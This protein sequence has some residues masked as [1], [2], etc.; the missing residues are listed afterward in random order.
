MGGAGCCD[1]KPFAELVEE[2]CSHCSRGSEIAELEWAARM[3]PLGTPSFWVIAS[4]VGAYFRS[5]PGDDSPTAMR[6]RAIARANSSL[7][8][9]LPTQRQ[10]ADS[11]DVPYEAANEGNAEGQGAFAQAPAITGDKADTQDVSAA[12]QPF[13]QLVPSMRKP[14]VLSLG[15][16]CCY[17]TDVSW[18]FH[19]YGKGSYL[20][21]KVE[22]AWKWV[23]KDLWVP[24]TMEWHEKSSFGH[25]VPGHGYGGATKVGKK[26]TEIPQRNIDRAGIYK[27]PGYPD[28]KWGDASPPKRVPGLARGECPPVGKVVIKDFSNMPIGSSLSIHASFG[29]GCMSRSKRKAAI[30]VSAARD[31]DGRVTTTPDDSKKKGGARQHHAPWGKGAKG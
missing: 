12:T 10:L 9:V 16:C 13:G 21:I 23:D 17:L 1:S 18:T 20:Y 8:S 19:P 5:H 28:N 3:L 25:T 4:G 27:G 14:P 31:R 15:G 11:L 2:P 7:A 29:S 6:V 26:W 30:T 24:C 22:L